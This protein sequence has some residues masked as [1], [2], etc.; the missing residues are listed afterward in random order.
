MVPLEAAARSSYGSRFSCRAFLMRTP[1]SARSLF[2]RVLSGN[3]TGS[4][5]VA[6]TGSTSG[7]TVAI[8]KISSGTGASIGSIAFASGAGANSGCTFTFSSSVTFAPGDV[9]EFAWPG[10]QDNSLAN[11][12]ITLLG[13]HS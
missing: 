2:G 5:C 6:A 3:L 9:I 4:Y 11:I 13:T 7:S 8:H 12:A 10:A 1:L